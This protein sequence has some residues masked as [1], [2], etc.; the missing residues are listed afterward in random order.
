MAKKKASKRPCVEVGKGGVGESGASSLIT[1]DVKSEISKLMV[2][3]TVE[4]SL[5]PNTGAAAMLVVNGAV[6]ASG[7]ITQQGSSIQAEAAP[8]A[9]VVAIVHTLPLF[10]DIVCIRL[11]ELSFRLDECDLVAAETEGTPRQACV[12]PCSGA[13]T[14]DWYAWNNLMPPKPDHFHIVGEVEVPNPGVDAE[15][16]LR[17]S[18]SKKTI[19]FDLVL[20]QRPGLWPQVL[21]WKPVR[22]DKVMT[23]ATYSKAQVWCGEKKIEEIPVEDVH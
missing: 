9:S 23:S 4:T 14:R 21:V 20:T 11:G 7:V 13:A 12:V 3:R 8:G 6:E 17:P 15:L 16:V 18:K 22:Y 1:H 19:A 5:C 10:N 2:L